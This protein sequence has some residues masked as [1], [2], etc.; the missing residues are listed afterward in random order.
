MLSAQSWGT[1]HCGLTEGWAGVASA[2]GARCRRSPRLGAM[3]GSVHKLPESEPALLPLHF[4]GRRGQMTLMSGCFAS[5]F[6]SCLRLTMF[7]SDAIQSGHINTSGT[8]F[9]TSNIE[10][11]ATTVRRRQE[12]SD[13]ACPFRLQNREVPQKEPR[14]SLFVFCGT[15]TLPSS[16]PHPQTCW[17][18]FNLCCAL[19]VSVGFRKDE[20]DSFITDAKTKV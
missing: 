2:P 5:I 8:I 15:S 11:K 1:A 19:G 16:P 13:P 18:K 17:L 4:M 9:L 12:L 3:P 7:S 14:R 20:D 6:M 10:P